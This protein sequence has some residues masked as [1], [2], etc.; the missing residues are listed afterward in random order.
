MTKEQI[1][2]QIKLRKILIML[3]SL[4]L[5]KMQTGG[6]HQDGDTKKYRTMISGYEEEIEYGKRRLLSCADEDRTS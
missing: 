1:E 2:D 3:C 6:E 4:I 5:R